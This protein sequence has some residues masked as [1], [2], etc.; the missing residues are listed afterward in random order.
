MGERVA[1]WESPSP[2]PPPPPPPPPRVQRPLPYE[3][4]FSEP[5]DV[6]PAP[7][8]S[9][10][11]IENSPNVI[12]SLWGRFVTRVGEPYVVKYGAGISPVEGENLRYVREN[13][14]LIVPRVF[15][16]YQQPVSETAVMTYIIME[17]IPGDTL[18]SLWESLGD[19]RKSS[20][21]LQLK[22][23]F[24]TLRALPHPGYF[25]SVGKKKFEDDIFWTPK[26]NPAVNGP[27]TTEEELING[28][29]ERTVREGGERAKHRVAF[30]R[31][32][33]PVV[34]RGNG[35]PVFTHADFQ[36]KNVMLRP[37]GRVVVV[38]WATSGWYPSYWEYALATYSCGLWNNDW[39]KYIAQV[40]EEFPNQYSWMATL[41][42]ELWA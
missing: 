19:S 39:H 40:L 7:L 6:L 9:L 32:V 41:R 42:T 26:P 2:P 33:L 20:I 35:D 28:L 13:T 3:I 38:D 10:E 29:L 15:A 4:L 12:K 36:L 21:A 24:T 27:F 18:Q 16:I 23:I 8:P 11:E 22:E 17:H 37:D 14:N 30:Y 31:R 1:S 5:A 25:G 34:F